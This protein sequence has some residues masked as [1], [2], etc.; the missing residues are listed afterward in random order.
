V[1]WWKLKVKARVSD[2]TVGLDYI[3]YMLRVAPYCHRAIAPVTRGH[4]GNSLYGP[5]LAEHL[6]KLNR[7][8]GTC[9]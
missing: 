6:Q 9:A 8:E 7:I 3:I 4:W 5:R 2:F 1:N